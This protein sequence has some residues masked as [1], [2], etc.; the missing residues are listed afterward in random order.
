MIGRLLIKGSTGALPATLLCLAVTETDVRLFAA[1]SFGSLYEID[2][3]KFRT[4]QAT[5]R[6]SLAM[7]SLDLAVE[8][9]GRISVGVPR[10]TAG[11]VRAVFDL[12]VNNA[13]GPTN[14]AGGGLADR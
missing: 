2:R 13:A 12:V 1:P 3:W 4:Y 10:T 5:I 8:R 9:M 14:Q 11:S 7:V 6:E